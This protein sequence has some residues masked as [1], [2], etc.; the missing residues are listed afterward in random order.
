MDLCNLST[1]R[2]VLREMNAGAED[3]QPSLETATNTNE[4]SLSLVHD[5][6]SVL[7]KIDQNNFSIEIF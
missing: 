2:V 6:K 4:M 1:R 5:E 7:N 3:L